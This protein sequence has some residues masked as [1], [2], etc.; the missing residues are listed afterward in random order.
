[1]PQTPIDSLRD[2]RLLSLAIKDV[3]NHLRLSAREVAG[4]MTLDFAPTN[5]LK[6]G[7]TSRT[8]NT[9]TAFVK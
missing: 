9:S 2:G 8:S 6:R 4:R 1:M 7:A 5:I 3:R